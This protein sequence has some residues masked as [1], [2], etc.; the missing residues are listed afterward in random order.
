MK[1]CSLSTEYWPKWKRNQPEYGYI[2]QP[3]SEIS[4]SMEYISQTRCEISQSMDISA[5]LEGK[6]AKVWIYQPN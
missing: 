5:K 1:L 2:S 6:S 3:R 4:Q